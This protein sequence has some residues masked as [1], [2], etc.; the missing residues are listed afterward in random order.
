M[1]KKSLSKSVCNFCDRPAN[2]EVLTDIEILAELMTGKTL[3]IQLCS[4]CFQSYATGN[5]FGQMQVHQNILSMILNA[6]DKASILSLKERIAE[7]APMS[8]RH[9]FGLN[10]Y[11][12]KN[13][14]PQELYE[15]L[16]K[17]VIG[18][19]LAKK[20]LS[21]AVFEHIRN[22]LNG[23]H[24]EK[25]N[26][27]FLGPS[28]SGKTLIV[29]TI[30]S[31]LEVPFVSGD[32]TSFSPTGFQGS[33]A[34]SCI[35]DLL[36]K[37]NGETS[38][39]EKGVVFIDEIDK[40]AS[41]HNS[42]TRLE[43]FHYSTQST[44]LKLIEGK[45]VKINPNALG[46]QSLFP[47]VV[48]TSRILFCFGGA[49]NDLEKIVAKKVGLSEGSIG[50][51]KS[52]KSTYESQ[53]KNYEIYNNVS[54]DV[55]VESLIEYGMATEFVGRIQSIVPL[56][57]L[58]KQQ[59]LYCLLDLENSPIK[60]TLLLFAESNVDVEFDEKYLDAVVEKA[61]KSG[62]GTRALNSIVKSS[63]SQAAFDHLG[64]LSTSKKRILLNEKCVA[65][66]K[67]YVTL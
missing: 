6:D 23:D 53:I 15:A 64:K 59:M 13:T 37:A 58:D 36:V 62:T 60:K 38:L 26:I 41:N 44:L 25:Q 56:V 18:Q 12:L 30:S 10:N 24:S 33:D 35:T 40:L 22:I 9:L 21:I 11:R 32:A 50:F 54:H 4:A 42:A 20:R 31:H 5:K 1:S 7:V 48:D 39:A 2:K 16:E 63:I 28:G 61:I 57:P 3:N 17:R 14:S 34:D 47:Y 8:K 19:D 49:F 29:N 65:N 52:E 45:K 51:R 27:L 46:E 43:S 67:E 55:L 66:P